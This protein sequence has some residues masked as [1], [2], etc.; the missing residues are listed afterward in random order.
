MMWKCAVKRLSQARDLRNERVQVWSSSQ[1]C[2][3]VE[4][5]LD[6]NTSD[7]IRLLNIAGMWP[8]IIFLCPIEALKAFTDW[9]VTQQCT[10]TQWQALLLCFVCG[11]N[12][13][14]L[15]QYWQRSLSAVGV[16]CREPAGSHSLTLLPLRLC[17]TCGAL[18]SKPAP[19]FQKKNSPS[20]KH[21]SRH[22]ALSFFSSESGHTHP[23]KEWLFQCF[24]F[25]LLSF[26]VEP[27]GRSSWEV[28]CA[29]SADFYLIIVFTMV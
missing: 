4:H 19:G 18:Q 26:I 24:P 25:P 5:C 6:A 28:F 1:A 10:Q 8:W 16:L 29:M 7:L 27:E 13:T 15:F 21:W 3:Q 14:L 2:S 23:Q 22:E 20:G 11:L 9:V 12:Q 17:V